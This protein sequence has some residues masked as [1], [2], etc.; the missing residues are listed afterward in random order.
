MKNEKW[1]DINLSFLL[2]NDIK[3]KEGKKN[4]DKNE[5]EKT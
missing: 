5:R 1:K 3:D 4:S 2:T